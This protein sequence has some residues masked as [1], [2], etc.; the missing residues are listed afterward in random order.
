MENLEEKIY[1][2]SYIELHGDNHSSDIATYLD[3]KLVDT[4]AKHVAFY[5]QNTSIFFELSE[6]VGYSNTILGIHR[7][8]SIKD[9]YLRIL[10][11]CNSP[12]LR[13]VRFVISKDG[14]IWSDNTHWTLAY[15]YKYG[16]NAKIAEIPSYIIDFR[17]CFPVIIDRNGVVFDS[18]TDIRNA[19][20]AAKAIQERLDLGWRPDKLSYNIGKLLND[21]ETVS[22]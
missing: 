18:L 8:A 10:N 11:M 2:F 13:A 16:V 17:G 22:R 14:R 20:S 3:V 12:C 6:K 7:T 1:Q 9:E 19:I 4:E 15:V 21:I 5:S